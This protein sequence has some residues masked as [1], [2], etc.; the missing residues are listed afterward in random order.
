MFIFVSFPSEF[1]LFVQVITALLNH[2]TRGCEPFS[3]E[4]EIKIPD[5]YFQREHKN[6]QQIKHEMKNSENSLVIW[7]NELVQGVID[8]AQFGQFGLVHTIQELY[9]SNSAG[10]LLSAFSRLFTIFLQVFFAS[11]SSFYNLP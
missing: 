2:L 11:L 3:L 4:K 9:G 7:K 5:Q 1:V 10:L 8:K 6:V